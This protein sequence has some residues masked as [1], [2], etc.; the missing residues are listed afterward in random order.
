MEMTHL[1]P[2]LCLRMSKGLSVGELVGSPY[3]IFLLLTLHKNK[4][5]NLVNRVYTNEFHEFW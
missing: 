1:S 5:Q 2:E 3:Y 4:Y